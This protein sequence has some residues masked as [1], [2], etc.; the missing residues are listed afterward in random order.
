M[1]ETPGVVAPSESI[2]PGWFERACRSRFLPWLLFAYVFFMTGR[3][4]FGSEGIAERDGYYHARLANLLPEIGMSRE[5]RW[6]QASLWKE[7]F[8]DKEFLFHVLMVPFCRDD[9]EPIWGAKW[10]SALLV[11]AVFAALYYV[12]KANS[13]RW[14]LLFAALP[15]CMG[16]TWLIRMMFIR[17]HVLSI[18]LTIA[19]M[20]FL[21]RSRWKALAVLSFVY[22]WSYTFPFTLAATALPFVAGRY[23]VERRLDWKSPAAAFGGA[24]SGLLIHP[25]TPYTLDSI[26]TL[27]D[28]LNSGLGRFAPFKSRV[29]S[30]LGGELYSRTMLEFFA[31]SPLLV[32]SLIGLFLLG[33]SIDARRKI[34]PEGLGVLYAAI[35]W[36]FVTAIYNRF[37]EYSVPLTAMAVAFVARDLLAGADLSAPLARRPRLYTASALLVALAL[38][39]LHAR[40]LRETHKVL[41]SCDPPRFRKAVAWMNHHLAPGETVVNLHWDDFPDLFYDCYRQNFLWGLDPCFTYRYDAE[42]YRLLKKAGSPSEILD[43]EKIGETF[44]ARYMAI[45]MK[46]GVYIGVI[47]KG[48]FKPVYE[49]EYC[50]ILPLTKPLDPDPTLDNK[51]PAPPPSGSGAG[52]DPGKR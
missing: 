38:A 6:T 12:L 11:T 29:V 3:I 21:I 17:S 13:V 5:F 39:A 23:I 41:D 50:M 19:G 1:T 40:G 36:V 44:N 28:I 18:L 48:R 8:C 2:L 31:S 37:V 46:K 27:A 9:A 14:P 35:A 47:V 49:D 25:Y 24:V 32:L 42:K 4:H 20:H 10:F 51:A 22:S 33:W 15:L 34:S 43:P 52:S 30:G 16:E 7:R 26:M 45:S